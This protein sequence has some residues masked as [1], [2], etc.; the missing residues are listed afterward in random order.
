M[1]LKIS[2]LD[3]FRDWCFVVWAYFCSWVT[4]F[5]ITLY[6]LIGTLPVWAVIY[7]KRYLKGTPELN[8]K[9]SAFA[10]LDYPDWSY[11]WVP[12]TGLLTGYPIRFTIA[13]T[14]KITYITVAFFALL[15]VNRKKPLSKWRL[16][17]LSAT[18]FLLSRAHLMACGCYSIQKVL[19]D[20]DYKKYLGPDW[21]PTYSK[22]GI[23]VSNHTSW[24][25]V[26]ATMYFDSPSF[27]SKE[28][29]SRIPIVA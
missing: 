7:S 14:I 13:F 17:I 18:R 8:K 27:L 2:A 20:V 10:R 6:V 3:Q 19:P 15:G 23:Q 21:K 24:L 25:D 11:L 26:V 22:S 29:N 4:P 5:W 12:L 1:S 28:E 9:Y 16:K